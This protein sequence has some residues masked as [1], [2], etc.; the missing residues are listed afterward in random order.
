MK[1]IKLPTAEQRANPAAPYFPRGTF[2]LWVASLLI[3]TLAGLLWPWNARSKEIAPTIEARPAATP[4]PETTR[5][6]RAQTDFLSG[7]T[8][9]PPAQSDAFVQHPGWQAYAT[10]FEQRWQALRRVRWE[11][12]SGWAATELPAEKQTPVFYP[13]GGPDALSGQ[14]HGR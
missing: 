4:N 14:S 2:L 11:A 1:I 5:Q 10:R 3:G 12:V 6:W 13:F 8:T 7:Q 9:L